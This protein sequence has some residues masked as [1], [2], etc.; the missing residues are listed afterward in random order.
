L[1]A[2]PASAIEPVHWISYVASFDLP[3]LLRPYWLM[4]RGRSQGF[5]GGGR[6]EV[7]TTVAAFMIITVLLFRIKK[8]EIKRDPSGIYGAARWATPAEI[9]Q[10]D[11]GLELGIDKD[12]RR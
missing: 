2:W 1:T 9:G 5:A 11:K 4:F 10:M 7:G 6:V 8:T 3:D 12:R